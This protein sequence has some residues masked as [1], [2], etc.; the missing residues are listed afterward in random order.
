[1]QT[2]RGCEMI[3][4]YFV[5]LFLPWSSQP[6]DQFLRWS[7]T[8]ITKNKT[9]ST[10]HCT[11]YYSY[12]H[13]CISE[14]ARLAVSESL[15]VLSDLLCPAP[16]EAWPGLDITQH[17]VMTWNTPREILETARYIYQKKENFFL[18]NLINNFQVMI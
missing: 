18:L 14:S 3:L 9:K 5:H 1:M 17:K 11:S 7:S 13:T 2:A 16:I 4:C 15:G 10:Q 6:L 8:L 12:L